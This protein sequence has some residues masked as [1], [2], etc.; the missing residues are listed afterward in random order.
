M[1][2]RD[3]PSSRAPEK[4]GLP[5]P[6]HISRIDGERFGIR[7]ARAE[8]VVATLEDGLEFCRT[9]A[10][11]LLVGRCRSD[12]IDAAQAMERHGFLLMDTVLHYDL[13]LR[14]ARTLRESALVTTRN[15]IEGETEAV[16]D[17]ARDT[18]RHYH[19]HYH[20]DERLD[21]D[22]AVDVYTSW[23]RRSCTDRKVCDLVLVAE[24]AGRIVGFLTMKRVDDSSA[25]LP[26]A[27][28]AAD[29]QGR[30]VHATLH[31]AM[32][33]HCSAQGLTRLIGSTQASNLAMQKNMLR[34]GWLPTH[35]EYTFHKW[36]DTRA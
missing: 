7:V 14:D 33:R 2:D 1:S 9:N 15:M 20:A 25:E 19:G 8:L 18:F 6:P 29:C 21:P 10:I 3:D 35:A 12:Q 4:T 24:L 28:V 13:A 5:S 30:R 36:F 16:V 11:E 32:V 23:A 17:V 27:G 22:D 31:N 34:A 26:L